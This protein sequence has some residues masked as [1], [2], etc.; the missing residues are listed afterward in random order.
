VVPDVVMDSNRGFLR[1]MDSDWFLD[2]TKEFSTRRL[3]QADFYEVPTK[4]YQIDGKQMGMPQGW[5]TSLYVMNV[6]LFEKNGV[7]L[8]PGFDE[9]WTP[10][11][12][13]R[14]L[15]SVVKYDGQGRMDPV[16]GADDTIFF[17]WLYSFGGDF[18]T[19]DQS[20]AATTTPE[21]LAAA[22]WYA[23]VHTGDRVFM[24]DGIDKRPELGQ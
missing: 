23:R 4:A 13:V 18:L 1:F 14:M 17:H 10:D 6:D 15:K 21:A 19:A 8:D 9:K 11:D 22:E 2:L 12:L 5:G 24:R 3:K 7:K 16:G 20:K